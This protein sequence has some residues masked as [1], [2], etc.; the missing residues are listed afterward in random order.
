MTYGPVAAY[1]GEL[2]ALNVRYSGASLAYQLA[3]ITISGGTPFIMTALIEETG[4]TTVVAVFV[5]LMGVIT[6]ASAWRLR[7]TNPASVRSDPQALPGL[8][9]AV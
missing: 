3:A 4:T 9:H 5:A 7:E 6:F 1:M 8:A 2:F